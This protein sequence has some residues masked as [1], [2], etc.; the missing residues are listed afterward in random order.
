MAVM[1]YDFHMLHNI[2]SECMPRVD[3]GMEWVKERV[4]IKNLYMKIPIEVT[5]SK[6][7]S[8][9][10]VPFST[11]NGKYLGKSMCKYIAKR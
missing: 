10:I 11:E 7:W 8:G 6:Y 4:K 2:I 5:L 1:F 9:K 3:S